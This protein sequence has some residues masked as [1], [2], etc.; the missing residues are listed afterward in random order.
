[1]FWVHS[2]RWP[3]ALQGGQTE[4]FFFRQVYNFNFWGDVSLWFRTG[5]LLV[6]ITPRMA[7]PTYILIVAML[8]HA[9]ESMLP[10]LRRYAKKDR[11]K[12]MGN[13]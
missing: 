2:S 10:I 3:D 11:E 1:M 4:E 12:F 13:L 9:V 7:A 8:R 5:P 6:H